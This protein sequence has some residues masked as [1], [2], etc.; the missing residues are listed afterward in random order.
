MVFNQTKAHQPL[1]KYANVN[2]LRFGHYTLTI[3]NCT[4]LIF[5]YLIVFFYYTQLPSL[6]A[7]PVG[8]SDSLR[9]V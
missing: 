9:A 3:F 4:Y 5:I 6:P 8:V 2:L 7:V 1:V